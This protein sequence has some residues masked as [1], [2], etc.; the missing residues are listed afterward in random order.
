MNDYSMTL[1]LTVTGLQ[2]EK[3]ARYVADHLAS[4]ANTHGYKVTAAVPVVA[5]VAKPS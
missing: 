5:Q 2:S 4:L 1:A 3:H